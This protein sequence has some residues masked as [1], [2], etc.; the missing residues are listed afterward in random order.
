MAERFNPKW[1]GPTA[2]RPVSS[3]EGATESSTPPPCPPASKS[4]RDR[5]VGLILPAHSLRAFG[6]LP[7][8][9]KNAP[10]L[11][12][13]GKTFPPSLFTPPEAASLLLSSL[14]TAAAPPP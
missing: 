5:T 14:V 4:C 7:M 11:P 9:G 10:D 1:Q 12:N 6:L 8:F 2:G 13:I 3:P